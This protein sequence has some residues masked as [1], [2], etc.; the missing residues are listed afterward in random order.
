METPLKIGI[1][2][3]EQNLADLFG[4]YCRLN[5]AGNMH[6]SVE[7]CEIRG[8]LNRAAFR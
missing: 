2:C 7:E 8:G 6:S 5:P 4:A 1:F 3:S